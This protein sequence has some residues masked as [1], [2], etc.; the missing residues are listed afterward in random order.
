MSAKISSHIRLDDLLASNPA[1]LAVD[2]M[3][4]LAP[5]GFSF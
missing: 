4:F 3:R 1:A 2:A 5:S